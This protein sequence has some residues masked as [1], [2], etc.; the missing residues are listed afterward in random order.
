VLLAVTCAAGVTAAV[1]DASTA[2]PALQFAQMGHWI[3]QPDQDTVFHINGASGTVDA[4]VGAAQMD[5]G[6][7]GTQVVEGPTSGYV[8]GKDRGTQFGKSTLHVESQF[9]LPTEPTGELPVGLEAAG[10]PYLVYRELGSVARIGGEEPVIMATGG[11]LA[12]PVVTPDGTLWLLRRN[13]NVLC[14]LTAKADVVNCFAN[15]PKGHSGALTVVGKQAVFVDTETNTLST[16]TERGL[17]RTV[18]VGQDL[19][20]DAKVAPV[21]VDGRVAVVDPRAGRLHLVDASRLNENRA[22]TVSVG[23]PPDA[24][25]TTPA[26]GRSSVVL[27]DRRGHRVHTYDR[28]GR[29]QGVTDVP[30]EGGEPQLRR[31]QD[32]RIYVDG[33]KGK[34]VLVVGDDGRTEKVQLTGPVRPG[35]NSGRPVPPPSEPVAPPVAGSAAARGPRPQS[36]NAPRVPATRGEPQRQQPTTPRR[37]PPGTATRPPA[38]TA[39]AAPRPAPPPAATPPGLPPGVKASVSGGTIRV[40]WGAAKANGATVTGYRV[41]WSGAESGSSIRPGSSRSFSITGLTRGRTYTI[42]VAAQNSAGRGSARSVRASTPAPAATRSVRVSRGASTTYGDS[43]RAPRCA[44]IRVV[45]RGFP[46]NTD[47][48]IDVFSTLWDEWNSGVHRTTDASGNLTISNQ[49][50]YNGTGGQVYV[51]ANGLE[52]NRLSSW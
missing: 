19:P 41:A 4:R 45:V 10:G 6:R 22:G 17:G 52:S 11:S 5:P 12:D 26:A 47:V 39:P 3:A 21:D 13:D 29:P 28:S 42:S 35:A 23:L 37:T 16:L 46:P 48:D 43:C 14:R 1:A 24:D 49:F 7:Q 32:Q 25:F 8:I 2:P 27:L 44:Y 33:G 20:A 51:T 31:G 50:P 40:T 9:P 30:V 34:N 18:D 36:D 15:A 38:G